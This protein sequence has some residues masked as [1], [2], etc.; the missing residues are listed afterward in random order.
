MILVSSSRSFRSL[1]MVSTSFSLVVRCSD[2]TSVAMGRSLFKAVYF[3]HPQLHLAALTQRH[4]VG[5]VGMLDSLARSMKAK[6]LD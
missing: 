3:I 1:A 6:G 5:W 4:D 2:G